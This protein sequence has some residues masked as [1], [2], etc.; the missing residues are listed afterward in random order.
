V[1]R[2]PGTTW[3]ISS[4]LD[5]R[6]LASRSGLQPVFKWAPAEDELDASPM[7]GIPVCEPRRRPGSRSSMTS[8]SVKLVQGGAPGNLCRPSTDME[9]LAVEAIAASGC[10]GWHGLD[11]AVQVLQVRCACGPGR[12]PPTSSLVASPWQSTHGSRVLSIRAWLNL[13]VWMGSGS[14]SRH[15]GA[16][17]CSSPPR[18]VHDPITFASQSPTTSRFPIQHSRLR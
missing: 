5:A 12:P 16:G 3:R 14:Q 18:L 10:R 1:K 8:T 2:S 15:G 9:R 7:A 4:L 6:A 13:R 17:A 11:A